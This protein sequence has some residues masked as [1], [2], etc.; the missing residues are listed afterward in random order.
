MSDEFDPMVSSL[1]F[2]Q[3]GH[4]I[5]LD[6]REKTAQRIQMIECPVCGSKVVVV[7]GYVI[8]VVRDE[9]ASE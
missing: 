9:S 8:A 1:T 2:C 5:R 7:S 6:V 4:R 3:E